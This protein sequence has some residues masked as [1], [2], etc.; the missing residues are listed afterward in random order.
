MLIHLKCIFLEKDPQQ[1][2]NNVFFRFDEARTEVYLLTYYKSTIESVTK[3]TTTTTSTTTNNSSSIQCWNNMSSTVNQQSIN[4]A[5][6]P[7][8]SDNNGNNINNNLVGLDYHQITEENLSLQEIQDEEEALN[9]SIED[10][11]DV[12]NFY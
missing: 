5:F 3:S 7:I 1:Q 4:S 10:Q 2:S 12:C 9:R 8:N 11:R 6:I